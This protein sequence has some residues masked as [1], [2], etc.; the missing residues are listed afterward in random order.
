MNFEPEKGFSLSN[1]GD[2]ELNIIN[3]EGKLNPELLTDIFKITD[4]QKDDYEAD[5]LETYLEKQN[6][7]LY[8]VDDHLYLVLNKRYFK[9]T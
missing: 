4:L 9:L 5:G 7:G 2:G 8:V 6:S 3:N 1:F